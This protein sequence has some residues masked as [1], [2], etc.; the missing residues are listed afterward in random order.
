MK[1]DPLRLGLGGYDA[2]DRFTLLGRPYQLGPMVLGIL[3]ETCS[4]AAAH[5]GGDAAH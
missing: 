4:W 5:E 3:D 2:T 1:T